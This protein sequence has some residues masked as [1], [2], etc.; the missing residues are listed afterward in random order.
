MLLFIT[1]TGAAQATKHAAIAAQQFKAKFVN[2]TF[3][4]PSAY[5]LIKIQAQRTYTNEE[6]YT[7]MDGELTGKLESIQNDISYQLGY[8]FRM[9][10]A[11]AKVA[12]TDGPEPSDN[13]G[14]PESELISMRKREEALINQINPIREKLSGSRS[15]LNQPAGYAFLLNAYAVNQYG[16]RV[17]VQYVLAYR[18]KGGLVL[19]TITKIN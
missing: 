17:I 8:I 1:I 6:L 13:W 2:K 12:R 16:R 7:A 3:F 5:R 18:I 9:K 19:D 10:E 14:D 11:R 15:H 4:D